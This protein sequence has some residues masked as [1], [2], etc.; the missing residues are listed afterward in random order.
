M[1]G[2][3]WQGLQFCSPRLLIEG[4]EHEKTGK[5]FGCLVAHAP[6][7]GQ[8]REGRSC[9]WGEFV[10]RVSGAMRSIGGDTELVHESMLDREDALAVSHEVAVSH[11]CQQCGLAF[12][13]AKA[14]GMHARVV[15]GL[16]N[17]INAKLV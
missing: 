10:A 5:N 13:S 11:V 7:S 2:L 12:I 4:V 6:H 8:P 1:F 9:F 16:R 15:H 3:R 17:P 14:R